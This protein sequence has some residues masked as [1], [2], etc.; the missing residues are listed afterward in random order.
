M[1]DGVEL[2][3]RRGTR[4]RS[5]VPPEQGLAAETSPVINATLAWHMVMPFATL[6][7]G[8]NVPRGA[9]SV[10]SRR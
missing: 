6:G 3:E 1:A 4:A 8:S 2:A 7:C 5:G 9:P 10:G